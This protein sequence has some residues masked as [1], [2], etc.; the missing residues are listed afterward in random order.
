M[1]QFIGTKIINAVAMTRQQHNDLRGWTVPADENPEDDGYLVEHVD[2][3]QPN[4]QGYVGY[5]SWSPAAVFNNAYRPT[6]N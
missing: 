5:V 3:G 1:Q 6:P 2:G 4:V